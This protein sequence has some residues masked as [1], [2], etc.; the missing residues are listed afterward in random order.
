MMTAISDEPGQALATA[1]SACLISDLHLD[2]TRPAVTAGFDGFLGS[3]Q[4]VDA[5][6]ILGDLFEAWIGDDDDRPLVQSVSNLL[7]GLHERDITLYLMPGNR[8]FLLGESFCARTGAQLLPDPC[9]HLIG[10]VRTLLMHGDSLCTGDVDYQS[11]RQM[12][13][14]PDW[15]ADVL[16][17]P[18]AERRRLASELR[19]MSQDA[20]S[21]KAD[22]IMDVDPGAVQ[23]VMHRWGVMRLVHGHTHRPATHEMTAGT[24]WVLGDWGSHSG[25]RIDIDT[26]GPVL[27]EFS[28]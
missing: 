17:R 24:R 14:D 22:D 10:G 4:H 25:W 19:A 11:F 21:L 12:T 27:Q 23:E 7:S 20:N 15:Q 5:L 1:A 9:V 6:Y 8:D 2:E 3:L 16:A 28:F 13:R 26:R 18:L